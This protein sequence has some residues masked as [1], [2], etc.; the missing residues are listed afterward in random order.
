MEPELEAD[1]SSPCTADVKNFITTPFTTALYRCVAMVVSIEASESELLARGPQA[2]SRKNC[3]ASKRLLKT[4]I[5]IKVV[6]KC[7]FA[8]GYE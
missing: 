7:Y 3:W 1:H 5:F 6:N 2:A 8:C 4:I